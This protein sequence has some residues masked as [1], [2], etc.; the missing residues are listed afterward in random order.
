M[1]GAA[2]DV[3]FRNV[4]NVEAF[5]MDSRVNFEK[6]KYVATCG[7]VS[8]DRLFSHALPCYLSAHYCLA[9][10]ETELRYHTKCL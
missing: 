9:D 6:F 3:A 10:E 7:L 1:K 4:L 8:E 5:A 2:S